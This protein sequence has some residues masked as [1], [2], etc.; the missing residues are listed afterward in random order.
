MGAG[1]N[2]AGVHGVV[3]LPS[4]TINTHTCAF[5][6]ALMLKKRL[7]VLLLLAV[8]SAAAGQTVCDSVEAPWRERFEGYGSGVEYMPPCW[9]AQRNY[10]M[11]YPPHLS[12][13]RA[14]GGA[15]S[16]VLYPG[17]SAESHYSMAI[18]P[19]L[20]GLASL[21]GLF[22]RFW[23][24]S[25]STAA[26]L[27][28][29]FCADTG[30]YTRAFEAIDTLHADQGARW[31]EA[32]IDLSA[33]GGNGRRLALR[34]ERALQPDGAEMYVDDVRIES[35]G[36]SEPT[37]SHV[38]STQLTLH[39]ETYG[40]G[41][42]EVACGADTVRP[43][44]A[45]LTFTG[46]TPDSLYTFS[47]GCAGGERQTV[48]VRT[49]ESAGMELAYY[50]DFGRTDSV[51]PRRWRRPTPN[52][53]QISDGVLRLMPSV[54]DSSMAV[55]PLPAGAA[56][57]D[58]TL[59][60]RLTATGTARLVAGAVEFPEEAATFT[61]IDTLEPQA[62]GRV[63]LPLHAY[64][65]TAPY[66][67]LLATGSGTVT[68]DDLRL[69]RCM[70]DNQRIYNIT[71]S[72]A[73]VAWDTLL[74]ADGATVLVEYGP[75]GFSPGTGT[76]LTATACPM[77]LAGL[78]NDTPYDLYVWPSCGD[79]PAACD[80]LTFRTFA[81]EVAPP[82]CE[83]FEGG[84]ALPQG[85][86]DGGG[87]TVGTN[88]YR[89]SRALRLAA[90]GSATMPLL[91]DATP[92]TCWLEFYAIGTGSLVVGRRATPYDPV[93]PTD[94]LTGNNAWRRYVVPVV[95]AAG[96]CLTLSASAVWSIDML[97]LR[98][99]ALRTAAVSGVELT[100]ARIEWSLYSGDSV[101]VEYAALAPGASDFTPGTGTLVASDSN[102]TLDGLQPDTRYGVHLSPLDGGE[103]AA[104]SYIAL[105]FTTLAPPLEVPFCQ[106]FDALAAGSY[107]NGWR[108][109]SA[110]GTYPIVSSQRNLTGGRSLLFSAQA[111]RPT[112]AVLPDADNCLPARTVAFWANSTTGH[113]AARLLTGYITDVTDASTFVAVDT[114]AFSRS[115]SWLHHMAHLDTVPG[116]LA[117]MLST[118]GAAA[119][120]YLEN[121]CVEPCVAHNIRVY[122][123]DSVS[124]KVRWDATDSLA[125]L[126]HVTGSGISRTDTL[127]TSPATIT[128]LD[129]NRSYTLTFEALCG[130]GSYGAAYYTG[131]GSTGSTANHGST[132]IGINTRPGTYRLPYCN[133]FDGLPT[134]RT[135]TAWTIRG[136]ASATDRNRHGGSHS[137]QCS[138]GSTLSLPPMAGVASAVVGFYIYGMHESLLADE[139]IVVGVMTNPDSAGTFTP[140]DT[141]RLTALGSWQHLVADM[142][143]Y[144]GDGQYITIVTPQGSGTLFI[145]D[146][147]MTAS[148]IGEATAT[149]AGEVAWRSWHGVDSVLIEYGPA[150]FAPG[151]NTGLRDTVR[152]GGTDG[153]HNHAL[154]GLVQGNS[155]DIYLTPFVGGITT[156][157]RL[158][159]SIAAAAATP[160]CED[161]EEALPA[162]IPFGWAVARSNNGTPTMATLG[163]SQTLHLHAAAGSPSVAA[164]PQLA[165]DDIGGH[166][167]TMHLRTSNHNRA[168]LVVGQMAVPTDP[169]TFVP[170][171]TLTL[172]TSASWHTVQLPLTRFSGTDHIALAAQATVQSVDIWVD[173]LTVTRGL[174][175]QVAVVSAR[176]LLLTNSDTDYYIDYAPVGTPAG[177]G[178]SEHITAASHL[179]TGLQPEQSYRLYS[180]HDGVPTCLEPVVVTM[181]SEESLPY[182]HQR[183]T[184]SSLVL[185]EVAIDSTRHLHLYFRLRGGT[186]VVAGVLAQRDDWS[187]FSAVDTVEAPAG[188]WGEEH[189]S[190]I[191]Y[192]GEGRFV[193]LRTV[194]GTNAIIDGLTVS[195]CELPTVSLTAD[196]HARIEGAGTVEYGPAGFAQGTGTTVAAPADVILANST[197]YDFYT[198]C[199]SGT[200]TCAAP[201]RLTTATDRCPLP[202]SLTVA[203]PGNGR[204][205]LGWDTAYGSFWV[206]Y[207]HSGGA[208][209][210]GTTVHV[211]APPLALLLDPDTLY[212][213]YVRCDSAEFTARPPQHVATLASSAPLPYCEG[214]E[215][216]LAGWRV[217][218]DRS[219]NY[220][221]VSAGN[222]RSGTASLK[223]SNYFGTTYLVLPQPDIDSLR[224][225]AVSFY[226]R[227]TGSNGHTV[228]LGTMS[229]AGDPQTFDSL[230][231][232]TS[233]QGAYKR[234]F[235]A[236][237]DYYGGG[238]FLA[239]RFCDD[240]IAYIDDL[241]VT[242]CAA[243]NFSMTEM[244][245]DHVTIAWQQTGSPAVSISYGPVG[246]GATTTVH[247]TAPPCRIDGLSPL[248]NYIFSVSHSCAETCDSMTAPPADTF[249]TFTPQ[250]G[251]GCIDYTDLQAPYVTCSH[252]SYQNPMATLG[253]VNHGYQSATS[254]HTVHFDT[255]ERDART[256]GLL[257]TIPAGEQASV[258]LGN[259]N[260][261]GNA[262][263]E[264]ES[265]T[266]G[267][268]VDASDAD[269]LVLRYAAV[270]QD[271]EHSPSL[272]PRFRLE[273]LNQEGHPID[274]CSVADFIANAALGWNQ[275]PNEVLWKDWTTVG[276]DLTP[277]NGQTIFVRLTTRDCGEGSH[278]GYAYFTLRCASR[279]MQSEGCSDVPDNRFTV[280]TGF[281]YRWYSSLDTTATLSD[282]ASIWVRSDNSVTYYCRLS[283][284]DNPQCHF[285]MSAF[286][287][288]RYPL[289]LFD[290]ALSV[291]NC[292]FDLQLTNRST[293]SGDGVTP[294]GTGEPVET[295]RWLL[296]DSTESTAAAPVIHIGDT[297]TV[298]VTLIAGIANNQ[299]LDTLRRTIAIRR[300]YPAAAISG[301]RD[302]CRNDARDT[303]H[304]LHATSYGWLDG[305]F[306]RAATIDS[307]D[308]SL[309]TFASAD[310]TLVCFTVDSNGCRDTL[311]HTLSV[312]PTYSRS[313]ADSVCSSDG[314]YPWLD[315][316]VGFTPSDTGLRARLH[317]LTRHGCDSTMTLRLHLWP[318][319]Y[320]HHTDSICDN[321]TLA[322]FDT[323]LNTTGLYTHHDTTTRGCDSA[324]SLALT[325]MPRGY[326]TDL[327]EVCD[328]LRWIDGTLYLRDTAGV[329]TTLATTFGCDSIVTLR[330]TVNS[331][332]Y[333]L[334][335]D[336]FCAATPYTFRGR[337]CTRGGTYADTLQT[338]RGCDSVLAV[339]LTRLEVPRLR[340][341]TVYHCDALSYSLVAHSS[342]PYLLWS[343]DRGDS[344]L[345]RQRHS[346][347]LDVAPDSATTYTLFTDYDERPR[348]PAT[349]AISLEPLTRPTALMRVTPQQLAPEHR[350]FEARD[351]G[352]QPYEAR[353]WYIDGE[354]QPTT[355]HI[356][357]GEAAEEAD[358]VEVWLVVYDGHCTDTAIALIPVRR[359]TFLLPNA[360]TPDA[361]SNNRFT[362]EGL[363]ISGYEITIYNR[364]GLTVYHSTDI[365][366]GWDGR[367]LNGNPC[368]PGNYVYHLR[369]STTFRPTS[370]QKEIGSVLLIR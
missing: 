120:A 142:G 67:A 103:A 29:G 326:S 189:V 199:D 236:L 279:R 214:F 257:R 175:P 187:T 123:L 243:Y 41:V 48:S 45:P 132:S 23:F 195:A 14:H 327:Q 70:L 25:P 275:G 368:P 85:W 63:L 282:S 171:D 19:P 47:V 158:K 309:T 111:G 234:C 339:A 150:G 105:T 99:A 116:H 75:A 119:T 81:H 179:I 334:Y 42:V 139:A 145:D 244:E 312:H 301:R 341:D 250:G 144:T 51:M 80:R 155:Y 126:C 229:D 46:L 273:I 356:L 22:L 101:A 354:E 297:G 285:T 232:F 153:M 291:A 217:L 114:M 124:V 304:V 5:K 207:M 181:P 277:Y 131:Y 50:E 40:A 26:R 324:A 176:S 255:T 262:A 127:L 36:T 7:I 315:T 73:T 60:M 251:T 266:Y 370:F 224:H 270:L 49:M 76:R 16:L 121:L 6:Y 147:T 1:G 58:L 2:A 293:I 238:R 358:T 322:F 359:S 198:L 196:N 129:S 12:A 133:N 190:L 185:P 109:L 212:D 182:C 258:R 353:A 366:Q 221:A 193:A 205:V 173:D 186:A 64:S 21:D 295:F 225:L 90:G 98:T 106:T 338:A 57:A 206:E 34:M 264:A 113:T 329:T 228:T 252:G 259:W 27:V 230:A 367:D 310:T 337:T 364:R 223:V 240:D 361:E 71:E 107:P 96:S 268:T 168:R 20:A 269:L 141:L 77:T 200:T 87:A 317:R 130:C 102:M 8:A 241:Q 89:G 137:L 271:P 263:P 28:V 226:A 284:V 265:I 37:V 160:Y 330:L 108:R 220:A 10:D 118:D 247:P 369:Y 260:S 213:I 88:S 112:V 289:A 227:L 163:G 56:L 55:M 344:L 92:D 202:D 78:D 261:G 219:G 191:A 43:A 110:V 286:A 362:V 254:R 233:L 30:R 165:V 95:G 62:D 314:S 204:V 17:T 184:V 82:Y 167:L 363:N 159:A 305:A 311:H 84:T 272:Q 201:L 320:P 170:H 318:S 249:Y 299:C 69:A 276:I 156:C 288:A 104:C 122:D 357:Y 143:A 4:H 248:T 321:H 178:T 194:D 287:G 83:G 231:A 215:D 33:Y 18:A 86:V 148:A 197:S 152:T 313:Y 157:Q 3:F 325:V 267:M 343:A 349:T 333:S 13:Q 59:A 340:V 11:G 134:G 218:A 222:A 39:F 328:S 245:A 68:V 246:D 79:A 235:H 146:L 352:E 298:A 174:A 294:L 342:T 350:T 53:P 346:A 365:G 74:L 283:F 290:T 151:D 9:V 24:L 100:S 203:Q 256:G 278:F 115:D 308:V 65:G 93:T 216:E 306:G 66:P 135:P 323:V 296:P 35:C 138:G 332:Y 72:E 331:S 140:V 38:G 335:L 237:R 149:A 15:A 31:Q 161:M 61:P 164:L 117:L 211:T 355:S 44:Q 169:N 54:G 180:S 302:R 188:T 208:A 303:L 128:G 274:S 162:G 292:Q 210:S 136:T 154:Q 91:G 172:S 183:D 281:N 52:Q 239:L 300:P 242:T 319:Y 97:S 125:L 347:T 316:T 336:T 209:G 307:N 348:C 280:P 351:I 345:D 253:A 177:E 166:Q 94:T 360:F 32:V 192:G